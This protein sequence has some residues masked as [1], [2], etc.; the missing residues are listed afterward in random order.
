MLW[1]GPYAPAHLLGFIYCGETHTAYWSMMQYAEPITVMP[2][3]LEGAAI[4]FLRADLARSSPTS[5]HHA[6]RDELVKR[7][8]LCDC[9][10]MCL[11]KKM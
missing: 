11:D 5:L 8:V 7:G 6:L 2:E 3:E 4:R 9:H 1:L 10:D